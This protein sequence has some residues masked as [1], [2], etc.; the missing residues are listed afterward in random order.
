MQF[1]NLLVLCGS[2]VCLLVGQAAPDLGLPAW[3]E[4]LGTIGVLL[5]VLVW[6]MR[7]VESRFDD[8][9][10]IITLIETLQQQNRDLHQN[11]E[12]AFQRCNEIM[13]ILLE[14]KRE[15]RFEDEFINR[16]R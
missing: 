8:F 16:N 14:E 2:L 10:K 5:F 12:K 7:R 15:K 4:Q 13:N 1:E 3:I 6:F 11:V 9:I